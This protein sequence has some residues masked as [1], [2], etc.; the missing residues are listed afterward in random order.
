MRPWERAAEILIACRPGWFS[1]RE[2][3]QAVDMD[4][5]IAMAWLKGLEARGLL[6]MRTSPKKPAKGIA[7][8]EFS[9]SKAWGGQG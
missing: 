9:V 2:V 5:Q 6:A 3:A 4:E 1:A 8:A 7:P